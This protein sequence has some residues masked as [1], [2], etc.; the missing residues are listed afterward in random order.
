MGF[1][2]QMIISFSA[3]Y[4]DYMVK[5]KYGRILFAFLVNNESNSYETTQQTSFFAEKSDVFVL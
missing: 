3:Y 1:L 5:I 4:H 2:H